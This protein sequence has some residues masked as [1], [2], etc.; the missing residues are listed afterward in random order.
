M[1][2]KVARSK[3]LRAALLRQFAG[4]VRLVY[5]LALESAG[6]G[7]GITATRGSCVARP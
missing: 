5:N 4:V 3:T 7:G 6:T 2:S 1:G